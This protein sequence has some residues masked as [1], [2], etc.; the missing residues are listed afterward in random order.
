MGI[1]GSVKSD[2]TLEVRVLFSYGNKCSWVTVIPVSS[3]TFRQAHLSNKT[4]K[5]E[6]VHK[7]ILRETFMIQVLCFDKCYFK[8][9]YQT[10]FLEVD[11]TLS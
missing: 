1:P 2:A 7:D 6:N 11:I 10:V 8:G 3:L 5:T 4:T 9:E